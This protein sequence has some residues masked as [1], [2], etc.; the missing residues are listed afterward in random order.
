MNVERPKNLAEYSAWLTST[1]DVDLSVG[2]KT[3]YEQV[4]ARI[5]ETL[6]NSALWGGIRRVL[7]ES[8]DQYAL[9]HGYELLASREEP[10]LYVKPFD[11]LVLKS[12]RRNV[13]ENEGW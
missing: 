1:L 11:S 6:R 8:H 4:V 2:E 13:V 12:F 9:K 7:L 5:R 10:L 3:Y